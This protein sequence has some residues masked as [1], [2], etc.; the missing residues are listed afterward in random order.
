[1]SDLDALEPDREIKQLRAL[2]AGKLRE[3]NAHISRLLTR[4]ENGFRDDL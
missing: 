3:Q 1:V 2:L 4:F